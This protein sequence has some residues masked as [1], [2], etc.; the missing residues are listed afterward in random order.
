MTAG[1]P[2]AVDVVVVGAGLAGLRAAQVVARAGR[3]VVVCEA[4]D[5]VG[6]RVRTDVVDGFL[7][8]RGFQILN[9]FYP[10]LRAAIDLDAL[11][12]RRFVPGAAVRDADGR[13]HRLADP[14]RV[15][16]WA[17]RTA[18]DP[19]LGPGEKVRVG[20]VTL[21]SLLVPPSRQARAPERSTADELAR[22]GLGGRPTETF[23]RPFL[24]GVL[25]DRDLET[26]S[27][28]F[29]LFWRS[30]ALGDLTLPSRGIGAVPAQL[31]ARLPAGTV[32]LETPVEQVAPGVVE[33][34]RG[35][36]RAGAVV[37]A[38]EG[39][40]AAGLLAG[41]VPPP[42]TFA[43]TTHYHVTTEP[44]T[45]QALLH[46][47]GAGGPVVNTTVLTAG[48][49]SY[50]PDHRHLVAS[51]VLGPDPLPGSELRGELTRIW[52]TPVGAWD[53]LATVRVPRA[54][55]AAIP[56][57]PEGL[58]R[59]VDLGDGLFV[60]GDHRDTPSTQGALVSGRRTAQEALAH[61]RRTRS[62]AEPDPSV[63]G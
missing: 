41:R 32:H 22:W 1:L 25:G 46:L 62:G 37:V 54:L 55:P 2:D 56:P 38:T 20:A 58:R 8:D 26:S 57:T 53:E 7:V 14:R 27:R 30:F 12:L 28:V 43:L 3:S 42:R 21:R 61:L 40:A 29:S 23:L 50:S 39:T 44:P 52:G 51:T 6:G 5:G 47:D 36:V 49:P 33:T 19:L 17:P 18:V 34:A 24:A 10:A 45:R 60:A 16:T 9:T 13:L 48:A 59:P 11:D 4:S 35:R 31:A 63:P 15:P